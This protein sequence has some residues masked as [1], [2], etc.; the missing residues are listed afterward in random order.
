M[1]DG[2]AGW[3]G[4]GGSGC[5]GTVSP[6]SPSQ[7]GQVLAARAGRMAA[8][9]SLLGA[10]AD[11]GGSGEGLA[12]LSSSAH[13]NISREGSHRGLPRT[14]RE[15]IHSSIRVSRSPD[16]KGQDAAGNWLLVP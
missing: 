14:G 10:A 4:A 12:I 13:L 15:K 3:A 6:N 7:K 16:N 2:G 1:G 8:T 9:T 5:R 11:R